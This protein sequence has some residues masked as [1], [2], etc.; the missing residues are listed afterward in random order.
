MAE[1]SPDPKMPWLPLALDCQLSQQHLTSIFPGLE[2]VKKTKLLRHKLG[3]RALIAYHLEA[4]GGERIILGKIRAKGTDYRSYGCQRA[5]WENGFHGH[6]EDSLSVPEPLGLVKPWQMWLQ[7]W[8]PGQ[9]STN[10][11]LTEPGLPEK[12]A[13]LA[14]KIHSYSVPTT[15]IHTIAAELQILGDR[16]REFVHQQPQWQKQIQHF[17]AQSER[18]GKLLE[19][20]S[21]PLTTIHRDF[22]PDQILVDGD[23]LW[24]V[25]LDLYCQ[26]DSALD[27][28]N[29][30]AH[31]TEYSLRIWGN[32]D[33]MVSQEQTLKTAFLAKQPQNNPY[34]S[35]AIDI[36]IVL[37]LMRH[38][39][40]SWR[41][42]ARRPNIPALIELCGDRL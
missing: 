22:Y 34:L 18:L 21:H 11:L 41:I 1:I 36:Y 27:L 24:L 12:V 38:I 30:I 10:L 25:D 26:G 5:L 37:T 7:R 15:K 14:H 13:A 9:L 20:Y 35:Q 19:Q 4:D 16:L 3:R 17:I 33:A 8:V 6:S 31:M 28:G 2:K 42:P 23:R 29:F 32:P 40:I 39:A